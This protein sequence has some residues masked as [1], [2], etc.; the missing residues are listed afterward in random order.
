MMLRHRLLARQVRKHLG[1]EPVLAPQWARLLAAVQEAYDQFDND[2]RLTERAMD[3][4][5]NELVVDG[6]RSSRRSSFVRTDP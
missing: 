5:S 4:S 1:P 2:R 3:L 6:T